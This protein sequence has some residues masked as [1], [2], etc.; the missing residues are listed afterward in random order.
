MAKTTTRKPVHLEAQGPKGD[1]QSMWEIIRKLHKG[2]E[3]ITVRDVWM[4]GA[5]WAPK[6]RV[7]DYVAGLVAAGYLRPIEGAP[8]PSVQYELMKDCGLDAPRVRKDGTEVTQGR[9]REQMWRTIKIIGEFTSQDLARAASTPDFPVAEKTANEYC[10]ML[11]GAGYL[12]TVR[13]GRPGRFARYRLITSRWTGPRAP[14][15]QRLKQVFDPNTGEVVYTRHGRDGG[16][17]A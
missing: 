1:R 17:D 16:G 14:M 8:G 9:G 15:I 6:G 2:G 5:E 4:L 12:Q 13:A 11:A 10:V 7:R 3:P